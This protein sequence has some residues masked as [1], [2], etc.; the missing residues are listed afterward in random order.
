MVAKLCSRSQGQPCSGSRSRAMMSSRRARSGEAV[1][2]GR[3]FPITLR[4][5]QSSMRP[6]FHGVNRARKG[7]WVGDEKFVGKIRS[8]RDD[9]ALGGRD[10]A[11]DGLGSGL[12][13]AA[14]I[15]AWLR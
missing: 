8:G 11:D 14:K 9:P 7:S 10:I 5:I 4:R 13:A 6:Q 3:A 1:I 15:G 12:G 2:T